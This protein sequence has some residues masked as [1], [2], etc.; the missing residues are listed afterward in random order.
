MNGKDTALALKAIAQAKADEYAAKLGALDSTQKNEKKALA[1]AKQVAQ[2]CMSFAD[3]DFKDRVY[4][5][6]VRTFGK[7][8]H[9][10]DAYK[11]V[12]E[13]LEGDDRESFVEFSYAVIMARHAYYTRLKATD[14]EALPVEKRFERG[15][16]ISTIDDI[17]RE[18]QLWWNANGCV[19]CEVIEV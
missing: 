17:L 14:P 9:D 7:D 15:I 8:F 6:Q 1:I 18:W 4:V 13:G 3:T 11:A 5:K 2:N 19:K 16:M 10:F 12:Y